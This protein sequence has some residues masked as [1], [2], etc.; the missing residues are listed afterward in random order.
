MHA[1]FNVAMPYRPT[2]YECC[3]KTAIE[4]S[5]DTPFDLELKWWFSVTCNECGMCIEGEGGEQLPD[6]LREIELSKNGTWGV[7]VRS[8]SPSDGDSSLRPEGT[9]NS[10]R[11]FARAT[12]ATAFQL[13]GCGLAHV[14]PPE[15][16]YLRRTRRDSPEEAPGLRRR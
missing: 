3:G 14:P 16:P 1:Q 2:P 5:G 6:D 11:A 7:L 12:V 9:P 13:F 8:G 15:A 10:R 4:S